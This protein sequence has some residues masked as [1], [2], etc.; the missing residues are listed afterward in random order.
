M[1][2]GNEKRKQFYIRWGLGSVI[3]IPC[4][5]GFGAKF[6]DLIALCKTKHVD[7]IFAFTPVINYLLA[8]MGFLCLFFWAIYG[9]MIDG[10]EQPKI[11]M[12]EIEERLDRQEDGL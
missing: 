7:G 1:T 10:I 6:M 11:T 9:G 4:F 12:L 2:T 8:S 5:I 3:I